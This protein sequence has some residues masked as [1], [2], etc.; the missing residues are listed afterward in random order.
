MADLN[1]ASI[2]AV[3]RL[4][5]AT[6][7]LEI[8]DG[9]TLSRAPLHEINTDEGNVAPLELGSLDGLIDWA[10]LAC[11]NEYRKLHELIVHVESPT[12]VRV[13][14][15]LRNIPRR[16][17]R[18]CVVVA[19]AELP[20]IDLSHWQSPDT[21]VQNAM[22][23]LTDD[24]ERRRL[25]ALVG[26]LESGTVVKTQDDG[27]SQTVT[28]KA[29]VHR[30]GEAAVHNPFVLQPYATFHEVSQ[31]QMPC[32]LRVQGSGSGQNVRLL[33]ADGGFWRGGA[34]DRIAS[35]LKTNLPSPL[36]LC[37]LR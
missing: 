7:P 22:V 35:Y 36:D 31:P 37:V 12:V 26:N 6:Q 33:P 17:A 20:D 10:R 1:A 27:V 15:C 11:D 23:A 16:P 32:F 28:V 24:A 8:V 18:A 34:V 3:E 4:V 25:L 5:R 14:T 2:E 9:V 13:L 30:V 29:G 19:E 21:F